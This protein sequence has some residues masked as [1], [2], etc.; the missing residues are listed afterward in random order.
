MKKLHAEDKKRRNKSRLAA[1]KMRMRGDLGD[2]ME[3]LFPM[4]DSDEEEEEEEAAEEEEEGE[5]EEEAAEGEFEDPSDRPDEDHGGDDA[6][7]D[8]AESGPREEPSDSPVEGAGEGQG[9]TAEEPAGDAYPAYRLLLPGVCTLINDDAL[10]GCKQCY[11]G[12][13]IAGTGI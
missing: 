10:T 2:S 9:E 13:E 8:A 12:T 3:N 5:E 4:S 11:R 6:G 7:A 1:A